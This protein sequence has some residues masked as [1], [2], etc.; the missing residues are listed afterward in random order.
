M[1]MHRILL[2]DDSKPSREA[3][4]RLNPPMMEVV[5]KDILKLLNAG[6]IYPI[7]ESKWVSLVQVLLKR[8]VLRLS[9]NLMVSWYPPE[10]KTDGGF[11]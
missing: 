3:Q 2:E 5:K 10:C 4:R 1:C 6:M 9:R 8:R 11:V 7:S